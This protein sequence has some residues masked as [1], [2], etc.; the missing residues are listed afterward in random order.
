[1][2]DLYARIL[3]AA[4]AGAHG[5]NNKPM[6]TKAQ[7]DAGNYAVGKVTIH[8]LPISIE[9]PRNSFREGVDPDGTHWRTRLA[10]DYGYIRGVRGADGDNIDV[11]VGLVPESQHVYVIN[12]VSP[13][14][15]QFD[16]HKVMLGFLD[17]ADARRSYME[18]YSRDWNGLGSIIPCTIEQLRWWLKNGDTTKPMTANSLPYDGNSE[19]T[20]WDENANPIGTDTAGLIYNLRREDG[21]GLLLDAVSV[22]DILEDSEGVETLDALIAPFSQVQ[23]KMTVLQSVMEAAGGNVKP[24]AMQVTEPFKQRGTTNVAAVFELSDGQTVS[25]F[26]H[27]PDTTPQK[28]KPT[29][30]LISWKWMLNKKD[31]TLLVAPEMGK[32]LN[33]REV[34]RRIMRLAEK[35]SARFVQANKDRAARLADIEMLKTTVQTKESE[36]AAL[37][38]EEADLQ[39]QLAAKQAA[40]FGNLSPFEKWRGDT[41]F[42]METQ[43]EMTSSD[44][45][46][47]AMAQDSM[48]EELF[49]AGETPAAAAAKILA[50]SRG[51]D[52]QAEPARKTW[53][54]IRATA[55][56]VKLSGGK[57]RYRWDGMDYGFVEDT[58]ITED[59]Q[60]NNP[61]RTSDGSLFENQA[62]AKT[63]ELEN[64]TKRRLIEDGFMVDDGAAADDGLP[65]PN[66]FSD[67]SEGKD[68]EIQPD[69]LAA[70]GVATITSLGSEN[71]YMQ[72]NGLNYYAK[73]MNTEDYAEG[74]WDFAQ[75]PNGKKAELTKVER[76]NAAYRFA[77]ASDEF[78]EWLAGATESSAF[79]EQAYQLDQP[80]S[81]LATSAAMDAEAKL[82]GATIEWGMF[83]G[84]TLDAVV[85]MLD[86]I[87][88]DGYVG[89]IMKGGQVVGLVDIGGDGKAMVYIGE[90][91]SKRVTL[92]NGFEAMYSDDDAAEMVRALFTNP[93][94]GIAGEEEPEAQPE[95]PAQ[96]EPRFKAVDIAKLVSG[97][98][99]FGQLY[100]DSGYRKQLAGIE[101]GLVA[102]G[103]KKWEATM[104][105]DK[106]RAINA[107]KANGIMNFMYAADAL[108]AAYELGLSAP[109]TI[110]AQPAN[111]ATVQQGPL[112][113]DGMASGTYDETRW[114]GS[115]IKLTAIDRSAAD[116][117]LVREGAATLTHVID[118]GK[119]LAVEWDGGTKARI[120]IRDQ[121]VVEVLSLVDNQPAA[122]Q[123]FTIE[124]VGEAMKQTGMG[125]VW[126]NDP[127]IND[128]INY[129]VSRGWLSR[130]ST[131]Q[132]QW[133]QAGADLLEAATED[134][135]QV[136]PTSP[137]DAELAAAAEA[138]AEVQRIARNLADPSTK[139]MVPMATLSNGNG[140]SISLWTAE[141]VNRAVAAVEEAEAQMSYGPFDPS[142]V[143]MP[144]AVQL[145][146]NKLN[147]LVLSDGMPGWSNGHILDIQQ[148]PKIITDAI[149]KYYVDENSHGIRKVGANAIDRLVSMAKNNRI[150]V[151]PKATYDT[152]FSGI[153]NTKLKG[154]KGN[155]TKTPLNAFV[156]VSEDSTLAVTVDKRYY[157]YFAKTYKGAEF[158][159]ADA[160]SALLV[161]HNGQIVGVMMPMRGINALKRALKAAN[162]PASQ[163]A[164]E[165]GGAGLSGSIRDPLKVNVF[166]PYEDGDI[167][168]LS[169]EKWQVRSDMSNGWYLTTTGNWRGTHPTIKGIKAM[170]ELIAA[171]EK[172]AVAEDAQAQPP[173][174]PVADP[175]LEQGDPQRTADIEL[176]Q[177]IIDHKADMMNPELAGDLEAVYA[178]AENDGELMGMFNRAAQAYSDYM[179]QSARAALA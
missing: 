88:D 126:Y 64:Y 108:Q 46:A 32:D 150:Q 23:R 131:T 113:W 114:F 153:D 11:F 17:E 170:T 45:D 97:A 34:A 71:I 40:P 19:M 159:A 1:M 174:D 62:K 8:G 138:G 103:M 125:S 15:G 178:R 63:Y 44:A 121:Y 14:T 122:P 154:G 59:R 163:P 85:D 167:V 67:G 26:F 87:T 76:I 75:F 60:A 147:G 89:K 94:N 49:A 95:E 25:I 157:G 143:K 160:E 21:D 102:M 134:A 28:I 98:I 123:E 57:Q 4:H 35:N 164:A 65:K 168:V 2:Q 48:M 10:A 155:V 152:E 156:L 133:T 116:R 176:M 128:P 82:H 56:W 161:K 179:V 118:G 96:A 129:G 42:E 79:P 171:I 53:E 61:W 39:A 109:T 73:V 104:L 144:T 69:K 6:P 137:T 136:E 162:M 101:K 77:S 105:I 58:R 151:F 139:N 141:D 51:D 107:R 78:K 20:Q 90:D 145:G 158:F 149:A 130:P 22:A 41:L 115:T 47:V 100:S 37:E 24:V 29:D 80:Y 18:S 93:V 13:K 16:E 120:S 84:K 7:H 92:E 83:G 43:G 36:L 33:V 68:I 175:A 117:G 74:E 177:S 124:Q 31:I 54:E 111:Q 106:A 27:N 135:A 146:L 140:V 30:D 142:Q 169:G 110:P 132:V 127:A 91:G 52:S 9:Q 119:A 66:K 172:E 38:A 72:K 99:P 50:K 3:S 173:A 12:Q 86:G 112:P 70:L 148:R 166:N 5:L 81:P 165:Q 55:K